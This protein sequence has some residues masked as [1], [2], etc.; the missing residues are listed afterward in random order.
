MDDVCAEVTKALEQALTAG[1]TEHEH[2]NRVVRK[3]VGRL[4]GERSRQR[5]MIVPVIVTM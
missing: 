3:A 1:N 2:L 4:V 5:P